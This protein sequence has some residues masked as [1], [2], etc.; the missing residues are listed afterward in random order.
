MHVLAD[1]R[2]IELRRHHSSDAAVLSA[3]G[4]DVGDGD[5]V[6]AL[7]RDDDDVLRI[8]R[9]RD[10]MVEVDGQRYRVRTHAQTVEQVLDEAGVALGPRDSVWQDDALIS[11]ST[12]LDAAVASCAMTRSSSRQRPERTVSNACGARAVRCRRERARAA[13]VDEPADGRA[14]VARGG[15]R[16]GPG[17]PRHA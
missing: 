17:R 2:A 14:G 15:H 9:A 5:R 13:V 1:G 6:T 12:P 16:A 11:M 8:D 7:R 3:A 10:V 4:I